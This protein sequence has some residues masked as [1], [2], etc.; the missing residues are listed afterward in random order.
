[1]DIR[2]PLKTSGRIRGASLYAAPVPVRRR[3]STEHDCGSAS[4][5]ASTVVSCATGSSFLARVVVAN[6]STARTPAVKKRSANATGLGMRRRLLPETQ[7]DLLHRPIARS[8]AIHCH[9][10]LAGGVLSAS[11]VARKPARQRR[12]IDATG[13]TMTL[14]DQSDR[15]GNA[16]TE[17]ITQTKSG[18][19][20]N[21][22][23]KRIRKRLRKI[24]LV[25]TAS[26]LRE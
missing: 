8:A 5:S 17:R 22:G 24:G 19:L 26:T 1:M 18:Q 2:S 16:S 4:L 9:R 6:R 11:A 3:H 20:T 23:A 12:G 14:T 7:T 10:R 21:G 15:P 13:N 25:T